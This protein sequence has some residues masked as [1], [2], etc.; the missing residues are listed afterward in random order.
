M[1]GGHSYM[2]EGGGPLVPRPVYE[3]FS[4]V[5]LGDRVAGVVT[6]LI[7]G[8]GICEGMYGYCSG[9]EWRIFSNSTIGVLR[10][11]R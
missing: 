3:S 7:F 10:P 9:L 2:T 4:V 6:W 8:D 5:C 11:E 1:L